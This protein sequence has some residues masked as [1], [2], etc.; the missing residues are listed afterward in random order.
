MLL[1][2]G[3]SLM[4]SV[5]ACSGAPTTPVESAEV[6]ASDAV[7]LTYAGKQGSGEALVGGE[8]R[9]NSAGCFTVNDYVLI[10]PSES[11]VLP[12]NKGIEVPGMGTIE[13]GDSVNGVG[14]NLDLAENEASQEQLD[15]STKKVDGRLEFAVLEG[16]A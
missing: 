3:M 11:T 14:G 16:P 5:Q 8:L 2:A 13:V 15:C 7:L 9:I 6:P 12:N 10:A 4:P 1:V